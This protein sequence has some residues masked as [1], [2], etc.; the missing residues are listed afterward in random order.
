MKAFREAPIDGEYPYVYL[1]AKYERVRSGGVVA[2]QAVLIAIGV[3]SDGRRRVLGIGLWPDESKPGWTEFLES[4]VKRGLS[5]VKLVISDAHLGLREAIRR[6][7]I[8]A[9]WQRCRVHFMRNVLAKVHR[10]K[11]PIVAAL[12]KTIFAQV[13]QEEARNKLAWVADQLRAGLPAV[14]DELE[15]AEEDVLTYMAFPEEHSDQAALDQRP[16]AAQPG[17][18][19]A[20][21]PGG[22]LPLRDLAV[23][24]R[25]RAPDGDRRRLA[26]G[27]A[28]HGGTVDDHGLSRAASAL[29][30]GR[31]AH[32]LKDQTM[33]PRKTQ[34]LFHT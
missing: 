15:T 28:L 17:V 30:S 21:A 12:V 2:P 32:R 27:Q 11:Q 23:A 22:D 20:H 18:W 1:D 10:S 34:P 9:A 31:S 26:G 13:S 5:G 4:L 3:R 29:R 8:G 16:G 14:A 25:D 33:H 6:V 24:F 19:D 7:F